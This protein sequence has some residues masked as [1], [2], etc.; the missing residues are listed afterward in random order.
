LLNQHLS[1]EGLS[2]EMAYDNDFAA[3]YSKIAKIYFE[4]KEVLNV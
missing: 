2:T 4:T 1:K 3:E